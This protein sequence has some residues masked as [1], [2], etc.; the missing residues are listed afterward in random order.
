M[1]W[2]TRAALQG[3]PDSAFNL[4][5]HQLRGEGTPRDPTAAAAWFEKSAAAGN[6]LAAAYLAGLYA[7]SDGVQRDLERALVLLDTAEARGLDV[8][9]TR[10]LVLKSRQ[11]DM[12]IIQPLGAAEE[13]PSGTPVEVD[14]P[15]V[16]T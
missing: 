1:T 9:D 13:R 11:D 4:G 8:Q 10:A 5:R 3:D 2:F 14:D 6:A 7:D 16:G 12:R 15:D